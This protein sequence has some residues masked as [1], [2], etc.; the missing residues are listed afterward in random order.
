MHFTKSCWERNYC[1]PCKSGLTFIMLFT[2]F[3]SL[4]MYYLVILSL[5]ENGVL[6]L[7]TIIT[8]PF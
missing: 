8:E 6:E 7:P 1:A 2:Y 4:L 3:I 5:I